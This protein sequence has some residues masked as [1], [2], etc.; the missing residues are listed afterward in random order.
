[1]NILEQLLFLALITS[2]IFILTFSWY[3]IVSS[4]NESKKIRQDYY[5]INVNYKITPEDFALLP[6]LIEECF[7][8]YLALNEAFKD[9]HYIDSKSEA[10]IVK[11]VSYKILN[12]ISPAMI[13]KL[14]LIYN[15]DGLGELINEK[16]YLRVMQYVIENNNGQEVAT[17]KK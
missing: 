13:D 17:Y 7:L 5:M 12:T 11:H 15:K 3:L 4:R 14:S 1:M 6:S 8:E 9:T 2:I 16:V 10:E